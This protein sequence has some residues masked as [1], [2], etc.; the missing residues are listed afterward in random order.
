MRITPPAVNHR[1]VAASKVYNRDLLIRDMTSGDKDYYQRYQILKQLKAWIT[2]LP[3][4]VASS[5]GN[6]ED[7]M[8]YVQYLQE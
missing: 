8:S 3:L 1:S 5:M 4:F 6:W 7:A 2:V